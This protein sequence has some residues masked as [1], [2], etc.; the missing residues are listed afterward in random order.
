MK[1]GTFRLTLMVAILAVALLMPATA[2]AKSFFIE[3]GLIGLSLGPSDDYGTPDLS[4]N[5]IVYVQ[6]SSVAG[7]KWYVRRFNL[8]TAAKSVV[9]ADAAY[10]LSSPAID[11]DWVAWVRNTDIRAKNIKTGTVKNVTND[12]ATTFE[13]GPMVSGNYVVWW[14][15]TAKVMAKN[16]SNSNAPFQVGAGTGGQYNPSI[17]GKRVA[18]LDSSN[19]HWN[20]YVKTIG[21][22]AAPKRITDNAVTQADPSIGSH[23]VAWR[24]GNA[25]GH[26]MIRYFD[27]NTGET[28]DG[29]TSTTHDMLNP[30]VSGDRILYDVS[31]GT[32]QD[33]IAWDTR[34]AKT[35][36]V[37]S[38]FSL[39]DT[40]QDDHW[41]KISGNEVVF[42]TGV[43]PY[44][45][46]LATPGI[47]LNSTPKRIAHGARLRLAGSISDQGHRVGFAKLGVER[48]VS[49][50]WA[51]IKTITASS[52]GAFST[53]TPKNYVKR[54]YRVVYDGTTSL[55]DANAIKHLS[56]T[57]KAKTAWPR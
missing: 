34:V 22:S 45:G 33:L 38:L 53:T 39:A 36:G 3:R 5:N 13:A 51:R 16:L 56:T 41:G 7:S 14:T 8:A 21:S 49:G 24:V 35:A 48:Y 55:F 57:S 40:T 46:R 20:V 26:W 23:L 4:G 27:Y 54:Q 42:M 18:Y 37:F 12:G 52:A 11:G 25:S 43:T 50:K 32:S 1:T 19:G 6:R 31:N 9:A 44:W 47:S 10:D 29:P 2:L 30:Q 15:G 17:F 28:Y